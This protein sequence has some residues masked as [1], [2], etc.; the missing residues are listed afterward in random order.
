[1]ARVDQI[2]VVDTL[3][4]GVECGDKIKS[5]ALEKPTGATVK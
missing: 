2:V 4:K 3:S 5:R 1:M